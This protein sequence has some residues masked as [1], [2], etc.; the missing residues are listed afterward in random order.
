MNCRVCKTKLTEKN[1]EPINKRK[2]R[3]HCSFKRLFNECDENIN[4]YVDNY[5][6]RSIVSTYVCSNCGT[7]NTNKGR[8]INWYFMEDVRCLNK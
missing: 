5:I 4:Y 8:Q 2:E 6:G 3:I 7:V 1:I